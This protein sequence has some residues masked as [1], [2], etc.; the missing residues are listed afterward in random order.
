[1]YSVWGLQRSTKEVGEGGRGPARKK[2]NH[3]E[4]KPEGYK[5]GSFRF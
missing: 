5:K 2:D 3:F 4:H 1:M